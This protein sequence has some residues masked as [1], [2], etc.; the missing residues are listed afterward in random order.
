MNTLR[1]FSAGADEMN[2]G[3]GGIGAVGHTLSLH[4]AVREGDA[5][6]DQS[7]ASLCA[8]R[9]VIDAALIETALGVGKSERS[10]GRQCKP[11]LQCDRKVR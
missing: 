4:L 2:G 3:V 6:D 7:R 1:H 10:H 9:I 11:V 8:L 5:G